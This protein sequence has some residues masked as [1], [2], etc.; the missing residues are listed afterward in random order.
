MYAW[1]WMYPVQY[2]SELNSQEGCIFVKCMDDI[3]WG[4]SANMIDDRSKC[5]KN[6]DKLEI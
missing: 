4:E 2:C 1:V 3:E 6:L 5:Q